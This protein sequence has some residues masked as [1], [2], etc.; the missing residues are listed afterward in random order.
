[1]DSNKIGTV[2]HRNVFV[3]DTRVD[4]LPPIIFQTS[5]KRRPPRAMVDNGELRVHRKQH[6]LSTRFDLNSKSIPAG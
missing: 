1:M 4:D 6:T 2:Y 5:T 3:Y